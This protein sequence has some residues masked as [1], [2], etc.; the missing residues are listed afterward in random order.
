MS[1]PKRVVHTFGWRLLTTVEEEMFHVRKSDAE[2]PPAG[3][4]RDSPCEYERTPACLGQ[5][6][7]AHCSCPDCWRRRLAK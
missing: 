1:E 2:V 3:A 6:S 7:G 5:P 4:L